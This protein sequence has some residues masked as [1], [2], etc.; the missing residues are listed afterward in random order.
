MQNPN[1]LA[2][3]VNIADVEKAVD[4]S[5]LQQALEAARQV[6][7]D[8][9]EGMTAMAATDVVPVTELADEDISVQELLNE[10]GISPVL[11]DRALKGLQMQ[12]SGRRVRGAGIT[13]PVKKKNDIRAK[14]KSQKQARKTSRR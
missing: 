12:M 13:R 10:A 6:E 4:N 5:Q 3:N 14:R 2:A 9:P 8:T 1:K 7:A 11:S